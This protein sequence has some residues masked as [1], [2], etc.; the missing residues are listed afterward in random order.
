VTRTILL[1]IFMLF[2]NALFVAS[3]R[4]AGD[5]MALVNVAAEPAFGPME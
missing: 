4:L 2:F 5:A 1:A 3:Q